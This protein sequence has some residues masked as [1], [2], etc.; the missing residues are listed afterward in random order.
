M[1]LMGKLAM[2]ATTGVAAALM[3]M[4]AMPA[5]WASGPF[6][7]EAVF[8]STIG[9]NPSAPTAFFQ[10][11]LDIVPRDLSPKFYVAAW[12]AL[13]GKP[14][15]ADQ[16]KALLGLPCCDLDSGMDGAFDQWQA[17]HQAVAGKPAGAVATGRW[18]NQ[19]G[20]PGYI[21]VCGED[22]MRV[23]ARTLRQR[24][25]SHGA[26]DP[27]VLDWLA[28]QDKVFAACGGAKTEPPMP[29]AAPD[30]LKRDRAYQIAAAHFYQGRF[31]QAA[32]EF[33]R[34]AADPDSPWR[35]LAAYLVARVL[36]RKADANSPAR[37]D[38]AAYQAARAAAEKVLADPGL[39]DRHDATRN[40]LRRILLA[41]DPVEAGRQFE[42]RLTTTTAADYLLQDIVDYRASK[43]M[44]D[45]PM[46]RWV[47]I[48]SS[49]PPTTPDDDP[50]LAYW[51]QQH[52]LPWLVAAM[53]GKLEDRQTI[54]ELIAASR[55][56]DRQS[57]AYIH[58]L[59][60]RI[61]LLI[62]SDRRAAAA[63]ELDGADFAAMDIP[64]RN[65]FLA[66][67]VA[68]ARTP[69][70]FFRAAPRRVFYFWN[71]GFDSDQPLA[72]PLKRSLKDVNPEITWRPELYRN[73]PAYFDQDAVDVFNDCLSL[74]AQ[75]SLLRGQDW[76]P[77]LRRQLAIFVFVR[78]VALQRIDMAQS[79]AGDLAAALPELG[80]T[81]TALR[82][83]Q[84]NE[85]RLFLMALVALRLPGGSIV[86]RPGLGYRIGPTYVGEYGPRWWGEDDIAHF[87]TQPGDGGP[88]PA[89]TCGAPFIARATF[90][91]AQAE[92]RRLGGIGT[93]ASY[94]GNIVLRYAARH[95]DDARVPQALHLAVRA[96]R[97]GEPDK[98]VSLDAYNLLHKRYA[99]SAW[100]RKTP[101]WYGE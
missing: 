58:L 60:H 53:T 97:Y 83:S 39:A 79:L 73:D 56:V 92:A 22:A 28:G 41:S 23:A 35:S 37:P 7:A 27:W 47:Q 98:K 96:T 17:A 67:R 3:T 57:P 77:H 43:T 87:Q 99:D 76:P 30:W 100:A 18:D 74:P 54:D 81:L 71:A 78:A 4:P 70:E 91:A 75:A 24:A 49:P 10:G 84:S 62:V 85:E 46:G 33:G 68:V 80:D 52:S 34:I 50:A 61:R 48:M 14:F 36:A 63:Q 72:P 1:A 5:A 44:G 15:D 29:A 88:S 9:L 45:H 40:L 59:Y 32:E 11:R 13:D 25:Q 82:Q 2:T 93:A 6:F 65:Q 95:P 94:L 89:Q 55:Q 26:K 64:T 69:E 12:R 20:R 31:D 51:R 38:L 90:D 16:A 8:V 86:L 19:P 101:F 66:L 21:P 42:T